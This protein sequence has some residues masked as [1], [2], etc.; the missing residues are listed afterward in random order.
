[1]PNRASLLP[2]NDPLRPEWGIL[3]DLLGKPVA[4]EADM[5]LADAARR[6]KENVF[7]AFGRDSGG[8]VVKMLHRKGDDHSR[9]ITLQ[10]EATSYPGGWP[11][12]RDEIAQRL[13]APMDGK[14]VVIT[15]EERGSSYNALGWWNPEKGGLVPYMRQRIKWVM[16]AIG[17]ER[18]LHAPNISLE[19]LHDVGVDIDESGSIVHMEITRDH[20][21]MSAL[22]ASSSDWQTWPEGQMRGIEAAIR[23]AQAGG[24]AMVGRFR[25]EYA[26]FSH[27][28]GSEVVPADSPAA[29]THQ[30]RELAIT[31]HRLVRGGLGDPETEKRLLAWNPAAVSFSHT[32]PGLSAE[33]EKYAKAGN[34]PARGREAVPMPVA[35]FIAVERISLESDGSARLVRLA[36]A[37]QRFWSA[38]AANEGDLATPNRPDYEYLAVVTGHEMKADAPAPELFSSIREMAQEWAEA[39]VRESGGKLAGRV[40]ALR[41]AVATYEP[42][43]DGYLGEYL[44]DPEVW[45]DPSAPSPLPEVTVMQAELFGEAAFGPAHEPTLS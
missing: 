13:I 14:Q 19:A 10:R 22:Q 9:F 27:M 31:A 3:S 16:D 33:F 38:H 32:F 8:F 24:A 36:R 18:A 37:A 44:R 45:K 2:C 42:A 41:R 30:L 21:G 15:D 7:E 40:T 34:T 17:R 39:A 20:D 1:M 12:L 5:T 11:A 43:K 25:M 26:L 4:P 6:M 29:R 23:R 35:E 28:I